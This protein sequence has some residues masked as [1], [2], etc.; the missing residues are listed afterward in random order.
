[1]KKIIAFCLC[2]ILI[3]ALGASAAFAAN[4]TPTPARAT[5]Q[6]VGTNV[7]LRSGPGTN[8]SSAGLVQNGDTFVNGG[9]TAGADGNN[10][11]YCS[12]TSGLHAGENGYVASQYTDY[13]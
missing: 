11:R 9:I 2:L 3:V 7:N 1:M 6:I 12:M 5:W 13:K 10:W 4:D 8:Y